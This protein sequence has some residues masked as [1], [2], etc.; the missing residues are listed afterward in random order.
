M[1]LKFKIEQKNISNKSNE[2]DK[3]VKKNKLKVSEI[4]RKQ[5]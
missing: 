5:M 1:I 3:K 4:P 2:G